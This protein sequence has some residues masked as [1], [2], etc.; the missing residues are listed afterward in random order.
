MKN[1]PVYELI[2]QYLPPDLTNIV[3]T[4]S[5]DLV[6]DLIL[7]SLNSFFMYSNSN[8][9]IISDLEKTVIIYLNEVKQREPRIK[10]EAKSK[11]FHFT[12]THLELINPQDKD[13]PFLLI[14]L[15]SSLEVLEGHIQLYIKQKCCLRATTKY[16]YYSFRNKRYAAQFLPPEETLN[17]NLLQVLACFDDPKL[18]MLAL[19]VY[20]NDITEDDISE[21]LEIL[22]VIG[23]ELANTR[24]I[25]FANFCHQHFYQMFKRCAKKI[26]L[27]TLPSIAEHKLVKNIFCHH[28]PHKTYCQAFLSTNTRKVDR[29]EMYAFLN[30]LVNFLPPEEEK[31]ATNLSVATEKAISYAFGCCSYYNTRPSAR[32]AL[33]FKAYSFGILSLLI[34][35]IATFLA[36]GKTSA[37]D[38]IRNCSIP[39]FVTMLM[40]TAYEAYR[41]RCCNHSRRYR[42]LGKSWGVDKT[43][44]GAIGGS[45][46]LV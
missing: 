24:F 33:I 14:Y 30:E 45:P 38:Y 32:N 40:L 46:D 31:K 16:R 26:N 41:T 1:N 39:F 44:Y 10:A 22:L 12:K 7:N 43:N 17:V 28:R 20:K 37:S 27:Q 11:Y 15:L 2:E 6:A 4:Y 5:P 19:T 18:F 13:F 34:P 29:K 35:A 21:I 25:T 42:L 8:S 23:N 9:H 3:D 36:S